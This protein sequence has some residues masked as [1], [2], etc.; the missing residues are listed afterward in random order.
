MAAL[1]GDPQVVAGVGATSVLG[2]Q[3]EQV[4]G[5]SKDLRELFR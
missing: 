5:R 3:W 4:E 1:A 2:G